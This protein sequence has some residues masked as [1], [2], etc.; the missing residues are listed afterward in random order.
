[1]K[2]EGEDKPTGSF[3]GNAQY[4]DSRQAVLLTLDV[5]QEEGEKAIKCIVTEEALLD[6]SRTTGGATDEATVMELFEHYEDNIKAQIDRKF[7]AG[8]FEE[9]GSILIRNP[10]D[11]TR[12]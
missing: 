2:W 5:R 8:E 9:D 10:D 3:R 7:K 4:S 6:A 12:E 1:M 11:L